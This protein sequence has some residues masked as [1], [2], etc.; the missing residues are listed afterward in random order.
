MADSGVLTED[1]GVTVR[2]MRDDVDDYAL[3][4]RW[5][6]APHVAEWWDTARSDL[7]LDGVI[8]KYRSR[9]R[10]D[11]PTTAC[12]IEVAG[13]PVGYIQYYL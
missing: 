11:D 8:A 10:P 6:T 9:T 5:R 4:L 7:D 12:I 13:L 2:R 1:S 3:V